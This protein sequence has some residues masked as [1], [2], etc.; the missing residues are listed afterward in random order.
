MGGFSGVPLYLFRCPFSVIRCS[1]SYV[2]LTFFGQRATEKDAAA[3]R[4]A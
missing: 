1:Q 2:L 4:A 3:P